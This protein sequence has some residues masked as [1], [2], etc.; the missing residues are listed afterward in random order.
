MDQER[1]D[2]LHNIYKKTALSC[3]FFSI[4]IIAIAVIYAYSIE[5]GVVLPS[6]GHASGLVH[7]AQMQLNSLTTSKPQM[8]GTS[9]DVA[10]SSGQSESIPKSEAAVTDIDYLNLDA[11]TVDS[12]YLWIPMPDGITSADITLENHYMDREMWIIIASDKADFYADAY[13]SGDVE[14]IEYGELVHTDDKVA[15]E[16]EASITLRFVFDRVYEFNT[17]FEDGVL[18]VDKVLPRELYSHIVII[19]PCGAVPDEYIMEDSATPT[20]ICLDIADKLQQLLAKDNIKIYQTCLD[21]RELSDEMRYEL[22]K[23]IKPDMLIRIETGY[24]DDT[25][26]YGTETV[27]NGTYFI[28]GFGSPELADI[29]E[30]N[31]TSAIGGKATGLVEAGDTDQVINH[32][33]VPAAAVRVG[34]YTNTQ[35]NIL[36]NREDYR[37]KI[38]QGLYNAIK[39]AIGE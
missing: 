33:I 6:G 39:E 3:M 34:Y 13:I 21:E 2:S 23:E 29:V 38:A 32:A 22:A 31:V 12:E 19:D 20:G 17:I 25:K 11:T 9:S 16:D 36:L 35:E 14:G 4:F 18:Y 27:Y 37:G 1:L 7:S 10:Q 28:P 24:N 26:V 30:R 5:S 15:K 8:Q